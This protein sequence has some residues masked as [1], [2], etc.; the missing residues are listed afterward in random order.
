MLSFHFQIGLMRFFGR[1]KPANDGLYA[2]GANPRTPPFAAFKFRHAQKPPGL[3]AGMCSFLVLNV[4]RRR[5]IAKVAKSIVARIAVNVVNVARGPCAGHVKPRQPIG[6]VPSFINA[7]NAVTFGPNVPGN[8]PR[9]NFTA[10]F[11]APSKAPC[12]GVVVQ[13]HAQLVKCD[14][15]M[16]H[17]INLP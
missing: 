9:N 17:A 6:S 2:V 4:A 1:I 15:K 8:G 7:D 5:N 16:A 3:V 10:R 14:V 11:D 13:Q 12:F